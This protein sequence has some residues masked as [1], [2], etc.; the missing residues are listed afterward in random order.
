MYNELGNPEVV[1]INAFSGVFAMTDII[2]STGHYWVTRA[3]HNVS[4]SLLQHTDHVM[5]PW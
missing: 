4:F 3:M 1:S 2:M 5:E